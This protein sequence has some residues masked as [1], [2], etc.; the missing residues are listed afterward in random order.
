MTLDALIAGFSNRL[1]VLTSASLPNETVLS[2]LKAAAAEL[3]DPGAQFDS[4][5]KRRI[6]F[7]QNE[8]FVEPDEVTIGTRF[9]R[10]QGQSL[11][12]NA[13]CRVFHTFQDRKVSIKQPR[14]LSRKKALNQS[15]KSLKSIAT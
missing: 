2:E 11:S 4:E 10:V 14:C 12:P 9:E 7:T 3:R 8:S 1:S 15:N 5:H 6:F 13:H